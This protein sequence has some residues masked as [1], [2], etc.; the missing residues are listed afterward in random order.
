M[1]YIKNHRNQI[2]NQYFNGS[3]E[4]LIEMFP[5][6]KSAIPPFEELLRAKLNERYGPFTR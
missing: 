6:L 1:R 2:R 5:F 3:E 4:K